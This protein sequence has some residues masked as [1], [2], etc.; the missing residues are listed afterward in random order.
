MD[1]AELRAW[2]PMRGNLGL[3]FAELRRLMP[4]TREAD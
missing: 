4:A 2:G 1:R 3:E